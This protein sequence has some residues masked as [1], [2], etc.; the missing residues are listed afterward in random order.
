MTNIESSSKIIPIDIEGMHCSSCALLIEKSIKNVSGVEKVNVNFSSAKAMVKADGTIS[1]SE[2][3]KAIEDAGYKGKIEDENHKEDETEKRNKETKHWWKKFSISAMLSIPMIIFMLYD[4]FPLPGAKIIMPWMAV[5]SLVLTIPILFVIGADFFK[6]AWSAFKMKSFNMYSLIAIGTG[7][8]FLYSLYNLLLFVYQTWSWIGLD[9][10]KIPNIYFEVASLLIMFVALGKFLEA[11]AKWST[12]QAIAKL[13]WL[14]PKTA[15]VKRGKDFVDVSIDEVKKWDIILVK[16]G[17]KVP[18]D[19]IIVSWYSSVDESMLT[20][21]SI[22]VEK[23]IW[24]KV[25]GWTLNKLGSFEFEVNKIG[26]ETALAQIIKLIQEAQWSKAPIQWF[27]DKVSWIFVPTVIIVAVLVFLAWFFV[28]WASFQSA[29]MY[30]SAVIVIACPCALWLATPTALMV[31]TGKWA[32]KWI[33]IKWWEPLETLCKVNAIVFDKTGTITEWK[34]KVTDVMMTNWY[35]EK[36]FLKIAVALEAKSE[37][38][39]A[40]AIV[41]YGKEKNVKKLAV[42]HFSAVPG[43]WVVGEI[44]GTKYYLWTKELLAEHKINLLN[45]DEIEALESDGKTVIDVY[46]RQLSIKP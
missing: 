33:L 12:S 28:F 36:F 46:K 30:F 35:E 10:E 37:H 38:P 41:D 4:F 23:T 19:W 39:L 34:P 11:K 32:E 16:P 3:I 42:T 25:F 21:E 17:E 44:D 5:I 7:V 2:L 20:G 13:M 14:A 22:P 8:A 6:W 29:L 31:G 18:V 1:Q 40:E 24:T 9:G 15:K 26:S 43:K 45:K 27:A